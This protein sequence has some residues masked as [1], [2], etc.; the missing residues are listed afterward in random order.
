MDS[1]YEREADAFA[2]NYLIPLSSYKRFAPT[3]Y[4]SDNEIK[5]FASSIGIHPGIV[6]VHADG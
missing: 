5:E 3:K 6:A 1:S 2:S 4:T